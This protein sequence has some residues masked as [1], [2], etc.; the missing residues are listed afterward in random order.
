M[1]IMPST[2]AKLM[3]DWK[4]TM[5]V[6]AKSEQ[7]AKTVGRIK[8]SAET[9][10]GEDGEQNNDDRSANEA[11]LFA[12]DRVNKIGVSFRQ[13]EEFLLALHQANAGKTAGTNRD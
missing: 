5:A 10:P 6:I 9:A 4:T 3:S 8:G 11:E 2:T 13:I 12:D 1:G 7:A